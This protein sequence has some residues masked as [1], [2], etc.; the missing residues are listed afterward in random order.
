MAPSRSSVHRRRFLGATAGIALAGCLGRGNEEPTEPGLDEHPAV[1]DSEGA[2]R[3]GPELSSAETVVVEFGDPSCSQCATYDD[4]TFSALKD[5]YV[6]SGRMAYV[7]RGRPTVA[8]WAT[9]GIA[10]LYATHDQD[11]PTFWWL[12]DRYYAEQASITTGAAVDRAVEWLGERDAVDGNTVRTAVAEGRYHERIDADREAAANSD[13]TS[14]PTFVLF[15]D[16]EY[17]TTVVGPQPIEVFE[18]ALDL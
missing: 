11:E 15:R 12:K 2:P 5:D 18:G 17:V 13:V 6:D 7:W 16:G 9:S 14:V 1:A 8:E 3:L 4:R 10:T